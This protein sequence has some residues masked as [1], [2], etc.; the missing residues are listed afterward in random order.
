[1][2]CRGQSPSQQQDEGEQW[3]EPFGQLNHQ[4]GKAQQLSRA[5]LGMPEPI[6]LQKMQ[7]QELVLG[8]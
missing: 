2:F 1:M 5:Y 4:A 6:L 7:H 3:H 8:Q